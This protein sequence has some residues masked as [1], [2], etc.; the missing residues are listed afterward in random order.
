MQSVVQSSWA[1]VLAAAVVVLLTATYLPAQAPFTLTLHTT[2]SSALDLELGGELSG[3]PPGSTRF[4]P[5]DELL[6]LPQLTYTVLDD[7]NFTGPTEVSGVALEE[8][9]RHLGAAPQSDLVV[10]IC[11]DQ[12]RTNYPRAYIAAHHPLL[13][14]NINGKPPSGWPKDSEGHGLD[15]GPF[16]ISHPKFTPAFKILSHDDE[17]QIPWGVVRLEFRNEKTVFGAIAPRGP[18]ALD[19]TVQAAYRIA[20][21][22]CYR[23]HN[24]GREGG[25]KAGI[26]WRELSAL[27]SAPEYF[28]AYIHDPRSKNSKS[29]MPAMTA[30]D[31]KTLGALT[32]YFQTFTLP[33]HKKEKAHP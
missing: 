23:C 22:N 14:L 11:D 1:R 29:E 30:Y 31:E 24:Q 3:L 12:Y 20:Q 2:R 26:S 16:L 15:M 4:I 19:A 17:P 33:P 6:Q 7:T 9:T 28:T 10:A 27:A 32:A 5:R 25:T 13:V 18:H 21:Q 8:L